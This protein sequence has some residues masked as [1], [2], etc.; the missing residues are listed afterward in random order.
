MTQIDERSKPMTNYNERL[1]EIL[2]LLHNSWLDDDYDAKDPDATEAKQAII[3][4]IEDE[5]RE[6][7]WKEKERIYEFATRKQA[8]GLYV[9]I[10][11]GIE[12][13][14]REQL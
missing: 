2:E 13:W 9:P 3:K 6:A 12:P 10:E 8:N 4:L 1:D 5:V 11:L 7:V 14:L